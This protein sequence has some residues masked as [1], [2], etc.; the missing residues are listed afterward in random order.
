MSDVAS[1]DSEVRTVLEAMRVGVLLVDAPGTIVWANSMY[2]E[3]TGRTPELLGRDYREFRDEEGTW[4]RP[5][6]DA[7]GSA[8]RDGRSS[9]FP[10]VRTRYPSPSPRATHVDIDVR[11][12]RAEGLGR[13]ARAMVL[14]QDVTDRVTEGRRASLFYEAFRSSTNPMQLTDA[15]GIMI[16]VNPAFEKNYGYSRQECIGRRPN[17]VRSRHTPP[18]IYDRMWVDLTDPSKGFWSGE[19]FNRDRHGHER[20]VLLT[21]TAVRAIGGETTNYLGVAVDL[22]EQRSWELRSA[23]ADKL[24][25]LGQ[26]AAGVAHEIN[27]PLANVMLVAES[28]RRRTSDPW[29]HSR[30]STMTE[31]IDAAARI[32]RGLLDFA[33]REEPHVTEVDLR[34]VGH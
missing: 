31:Q 24:A 21:I 5:I 2:F 17:L 27:T 1:V 23:H 7:V 20:P 15:S 4:S 29:V 12:V 28:L 33:R 6:R 34:T 3:T 13:P 16:D 14:L 19:I 32:V 8:L 22:T 25:S 26:L 11:A 9:A 30:L 18:E 10:S